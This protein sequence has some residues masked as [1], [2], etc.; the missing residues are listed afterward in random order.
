MIGEPELILRLVLATGSAALLGFERGVAQ[1]PAGLRTHALVGLGAALFTIAGSLGWAETGALDA[2]PTRV[3]AQIVSGLGFI[4]A[5]AI[6]RNGTS[7]SGLTTAST[8]WA[9]GALGIAY[10]VGLYEIATA[11][12]VLALVTLVAFR[13]LRT[14][15]ERVGYRTAQIEL[16][17]E[18]GRGTMRSL[19]EAIALS[20][21]NIERLE[22]DDEPA[23]QVG[24]SVRSVTVAFRVHKRDS[25]YVDAVQQLTDLPEVR[26]VHLR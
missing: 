7:V 13:P 11:A 14:L 5:G 22:I 3:A 1:R 10:A 24:P 6:L 25:R 2:D 20:D 21:A 4:G 8:V 9:S 17:Y 19:L 15:S 23:D 18:Q 12:L 26:S 16:N